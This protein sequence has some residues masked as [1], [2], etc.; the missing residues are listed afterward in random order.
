MAHIS[1]KNLSIVF[2]IFDSSSRSIKRKIID[3]AI[4][5][6]IKNNEK[7]NLINVKA[8]SEINLEINDGD[9]VGVYGH[10]GSGKSTLLRVIS[11]I[12]KPFPGNGE[13]IVN[14]KVVSLIDIYIG[15]EEELTGREN[16]FI[17]GILLG[18]SI[19]EINNFIGKIIDFSE[20]ED[21]IDLPVRIYSSGMVLRLIFSINM[22][23]SPEIL[24]LDEWISVGDE[25]FKKK[26][27]KKIQE[28][29]LTTKILVIAS[30]SLDLLKKNCNKII[31]LEKGKI[32]KI[33]NSLINNL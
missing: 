19:K 29:L 11:G 18:H 6:K 1:L 20:L 8:L 23:A 30:H 25:N 27:E 22:M 24:L 14:G 12:Y 13:V 10:N 3:K 4:G 33:E 5:G 21:Y 9:R 32:A 26:A 17:R 28:I 15:I 7:T 31:F 2:P 16:I